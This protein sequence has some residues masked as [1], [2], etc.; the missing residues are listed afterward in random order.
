M[1]SAP[2]LTI[3]A[4]ADRTGIAVPTLRAWEARYGYPRPERLASGH[5]RYSE[6]DCEV[7]ARVVAE[8]DR[9]L[10]VPAAIERALAVTDEVP[11]SVF[12]ALR[13]TRPD[14]TPSVLSKRSLVALSEAIEDEY[15][16]RAAHGVVLG[17]F[18]RERYYRRTEA[19]W[20]ELARSAGDAVVFADFHGRADPADGPAEVPLPPSAPLLREWVVVCDAP[21]FAACLAGWERAGQDAADPARR[22]EAFWTVE[23]DVVRQATSILLGLA[24][25]T[26]PGLADR[27]RAHL[28]A[29]APADVAALRA[30]TALTNRM[31]AALEP[32]QRPSWTAPPDPAGS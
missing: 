6:H 23:P 17:C 22:F 11:K 21:H 8:R 12:A 15:C 1:S 19:R 27:I 32:T 7:L 2:G 5:R 14:L 16:A 26:A 29:P 4:V 13:R 28:A 3:A 30:A 9:G 31:V 18:Q 25:E 20:R 24:D 10:S